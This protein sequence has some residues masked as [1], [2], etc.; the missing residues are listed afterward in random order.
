[1][2]GECTTVQNDPIYLFEIKGEFGLLYKI[3]HKIL[4]K[5][6]IG[7]TAGAVD[8]SLFYLFIFLFDGK[9]RIAEHTYL[10]PQFPWG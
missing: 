1:M 8:N 7:T 3:L 6:K 9:G 5:R 4:H 2:L 10:R